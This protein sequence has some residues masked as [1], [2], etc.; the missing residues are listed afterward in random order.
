MSNRVKRFQGGGPMVDLERNKKQAKL[1]EDVYYNNP[2][3][4]SAM[5]QRH[6]EA[7]YGPI[8]DRVEKLYRQNP[9]EQYLKNLIPLYRNVYDPHG[10]TEFNDTTNVVPSSARRT[11]PS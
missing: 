8:F 11:I 6:G 10:F 3:S 9:S 7:L 4:V 2:D 5:N 1:Y